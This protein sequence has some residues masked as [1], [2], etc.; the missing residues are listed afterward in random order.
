MKTIAEY[1]TVFEKLP[2]KSKNKFMVTTYTTSDTI[3]LIEEETS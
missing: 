1:E 3:A 2:N